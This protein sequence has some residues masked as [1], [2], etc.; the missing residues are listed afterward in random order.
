MECAVPDTI[1]SNRLSALESKTEV[2]I[3]AIQE[4]NERLNQIITGNGNPKEGLVF[5]V[6]VLEEDKARLGV[7]LNWMI[8][9]VSLIGTTVIGE[10]IVKFYVHQKGP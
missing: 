2:L 9:T 1:I 7:I 3:N 8:G 5:K 4:N 6:S 10:A